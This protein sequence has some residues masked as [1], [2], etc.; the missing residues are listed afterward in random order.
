[1]PLSK[2]IAE[3]IQ[4]SRIFDE[5]F[6][7]SQAQIGS[8]T[9]DAIAH[10]LTT[11]EALGLWP[12]P[13]FDPA[14]YALQIDGLGEETN[15]LTHYL[16]LG[17]RVGLRT[18]ALFD[19][20]FYVTHNPGVLAAGVNPLAHFLASGGLEGRRP[21]PMFDSHLY[22]QKFPALQETRENPLVHYLRYGWRIGADPHLLFSTAFYLADNKDVSNSGVNPLLHFVTTGLQEGRRPNYRF[23]RDAFK[24]IGADAAR[25]LTEQVILDACL[26][27]PDPEQEYHALKREIGLHRGPVPQ[28]VLEGRTLPIAFYLPQFHPIPAN[29]LNWGEGFTEWVN[30]RQAKPNFMGHDQPRIPGE[31]GYYDLRDPDIM[32]KQAQLAQAYGVHGFCFYWYWF[33]G[34]KPLALPLEKMLE[35]SHPNMPFCLCWANEGWTRKW[36]GGVE[37]IF[38]HKYSDEDDRVHARELVRYMNDPR[39]IRLNGAPLLLIYRAGALPAS[40]EYLKRWRAMFQALGIPTIHFSLVESA[41]FAWALTDPRPLGFDSSVE[42]PPHGAKGALPPLQTM[43]N[44]A[45]NG[46]IFDYRQTVLRYATAPQPNYPRF[47]TVMGAWDNTARYQDKSS[48]F[49]CAT[50][51]AYRAWLEAAIADVE[52]THSPGERLVF[53]NAWNEWGEG[54]YLEPDDKWGRQYLEATAAAFKGV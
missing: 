25:L 21:H 37:L 30:V 44:P 31:L 11:G 12:N 3:L 6:Y 23:S 26:D 20:E 34:Q 45:F 4:S 42:F 39:Y 32:E 38:G 35:T 54:T 46:A 36:A 14:Y 41:E 40:A 1:M 28:A 22:M 33:N 29:D 19:T 5:E 8:P 27:L 43:T 52:A 16:R 18:H 53:I 2:E 9:S 17:W 24:K 10:Y 51:G 47:R 48:L 7:R 15:L 50:P 13:L 49:M